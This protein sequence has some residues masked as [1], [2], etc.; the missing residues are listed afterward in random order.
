MTT[1]T[2]L[3]AIPP[4]RFA[5]ER[6]GYQAAGH[7]EVAMAT[8][9]QRQAPRGNVGEAAGARREL[10]EEARRSNIPGRSKTGRAELA[11]VLGEP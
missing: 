9:K 6:S 5:P 3:L 8:P 4:C 1:P 7:R 2:T 10:S 11:R